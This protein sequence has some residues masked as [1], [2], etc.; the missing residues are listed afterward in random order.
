MRPT[1]AL[2][3]VLSFIVAFPLL[4]GREAPASTIPS[5]TD[6]GLDPVNLIFKGF[7]PAWWV[8]QNLN[9]WN[10]TPCSEPKTLEGR[11]YD[12]TLETPDT[13]GQFPPC[14]GPRFHIRVWDMGVDPVLGHWSIGA[15]HH[16]HTVCNPVCHHVIDGWEN[17]E[18]Q[19][20]STFTLSATTVSI[21]NYTLPNSGYYQNYYNDGIAALIQLSSPRTYPVS[22]TETGLRLGTLWSITL[23]QTTLSSTS[24]N[25]LFS[26]S[27]GTYSFTVAP[28]TGYTDVPTSGIL[29]VTGNLVAQPVEFTP[30]AYYVSFSETGL[31]AGTTWSVML[32]GTIQQSTEKA[33]T[34]QVSKGSHPFSIQSPNGYM[35][36]PSGGTL[37]V[38]ADTTVRV[39]YNTMQTV[40]SALKQPGVV[41]LIYTTVAAWALVALAA[42]LTVWR[43]RKPAGG[44]D[45]TISEQQPALW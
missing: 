22:F 23:N 8:V 39:S 26:A 1:V 19:I 2:L 40:Q 20:R 7:A 13:K 18:Q 6:D 37:A 15:V 31:P 5:Q 14:Y 4:P 38:A 42:L 33:I 29:T 16:E 10:P 43:A 28:V 34:F 30:L 32:D 3:I 44:D 35:S 12:F 24:D 27:N 36:N 45:R 9:G 21:S 11:T 25:I 41:F 17:A